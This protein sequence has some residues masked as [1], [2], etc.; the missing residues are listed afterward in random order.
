[1]Y[2]LKLPFLVQSCQPGWVWLHSPGSHASPA[3]TQP[4]GAA[5]DGSLAITSSPH[6]AIIHPH[7]TVFPT[8]VSYLSSFHFGVAMTTYAVGRKGSIS[9]CGHLQRLH[10]G[11]R[12]SCEAPGQMLLSCN[13]PSEN[14]QLTDQRKTNFLLSFYLNMLPIQKAGSFHHH[15]ALPMYSIAAI[16][17]RERAE[18]VQWWQHQEFVLWELSPA[19][20]W[21]GRERLEWKGTAGISRLSLEIRGLP[22]FRWMCCRPAACSVSWKPMHAAPGCVQWHFCPKRFVGTI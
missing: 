10:N 15:S 8:S 14:A 17:G 12:I 11:A 3:P 18:V 6:L 16:T 4:M 13:H 20:G 21:N 9:F 1:M 7:R 22:G 5:A 19:A 2:W